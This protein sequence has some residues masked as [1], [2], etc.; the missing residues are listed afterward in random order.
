MAFRYLFS[1]IKSGIRT[2]CSSYAMCV[3]CI[4]IGITLIAFS[5]GLVYHLQASEKDSSSENKELSI[6]LYDDCY[7]GI[8]YEERKERLE[9]EFVKKKDVVET[10]LHLPNETLNNLHFI[11]M[12]VKF[13]E[14]LAKDL[15]I[16][17]Y[18]LTCTTT[19]KVQDQ[20]VTGGNLDDYFKSIGR[21]A[22]GRYFSKEEEKEGALVCVESHW[23]I[24]HTGNYF[25]SKTREPLDD[26]NV[27]NKYRKTTQG[28]YIIHG[29]EYKCIGSYRYPGTIPEVP[30][31]TLDDDVYVAKID[32]YFDNPITRNDYETICTAFQEKYGNLTSVWPLNLP[33]AVNARFT[34]TLLVICLLIAFLSGSITAFI[35]Q[36]LLQR[37]S[38]TFRIYRLCGMSAE[39]VRALCFA[40]FIALQVFSVL[41]GLLGYHF[42]LMPILDKSLVYLSDAYNPANY[43]KL[44]A[45]YLAISLSIVIFMMN[46]EEMRN[47]WVNM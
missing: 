34:N 41:I 19:F 45:L 9:S 10:I 26:I 1:K 28:T 21:I 25:N 16:D 38:R 37:S 12:S 46:S 32:F 3:L 6:R 17:A 2:D 5:F 47:T 27:A 44:A 14:D 40:E 11:M 36:Y 31:S 35:Y 24:D 20:K 4:S 39:Q 43:I 42:I 29:K 15:D 8:S 30:F 18:L 7:K 33:E 13:K 23:D 22:E